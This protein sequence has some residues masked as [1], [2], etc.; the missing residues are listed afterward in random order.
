MPI[1]PSEFEEA[2]RLV[3]TMEYMGIDIWHLKN[4]NTVK[5]IGFIRKQKMQGWRAGVSDYLVFIPKEKSRLNEGKVLFIELKR[6]KRKLKN[7]NIG[8]SPSKIY[9]AQVEFIRKMDSV[10]IIGAKI[11]YGADQ[12]IEFVEQYINQKKI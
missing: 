12:A 6:A 8:K 1:I 4:E 11:C 7:G 3:Q 2:V 9:D 10:S 5:S